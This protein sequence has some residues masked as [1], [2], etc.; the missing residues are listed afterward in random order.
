M[1]EKPWIEKPPFQVFIGVVIMSNALTI[2]LETDMA[3]PEAVAIKDR[4]EWFVIEN[5][6]CVVFLVELLLRLAYQ[7]MAYFKEAW[8]LCDFALVVLAIVDTW[9]LSAVVQDA[10]GGG[11]LRVLSVLRV[12]RMMR[13]ARLIRLLR[14]FR[15]LWLIVNGLIESM[16]TLFWVSLLLVL[17]LYVCA[18]FLTMQV[19]KNDLMYME[20]RKL[21]GGWDY[22]KYFGTVPASMYTLFQML[23]LESWADGVARHVVSNQPVLALF[24]L[25]FLLITTFGLLNLVVGV[26]VENTLT[27]AANNEEKIKKQQEKDRARTLEYLREIFEMADE[28][29]SGTLELEEFQS[30]LEDP[31]VLKKLRMVDLPVQEAEA[32]FTVLDADGSGSPP[33]TSSLVAA[34]VSREMRRV[35]IC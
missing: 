27:A 25:I 32:L 3:D 9:I 4:L 30:A 14:S 20:Y 17:F 24:F 28:D 10:E 6:F 15:E 29:R 5:V 19:G 21:S 33:W 31:E 11:N 35:R 8:N 26:I 22:Q 18:I 7:R 13:L 2:G 34:C 23:T 1:G 12:I 16:K